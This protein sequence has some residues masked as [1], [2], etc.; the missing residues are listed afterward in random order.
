MIFFIPKWLIRD[1][2]TEDTVMKIIQEYFNSKGFVHQQL[3]SFNHMIQH[4]L[5]TIVGEESVISAEIKP[6]VEY[7]VEFGQVHVDK[8]YVIEEDRTNIFGT[9]CKKIFLFFTC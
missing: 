2:N 3:S 9:A 6:G 7:R 5:Q 8:P 4:D 1:M